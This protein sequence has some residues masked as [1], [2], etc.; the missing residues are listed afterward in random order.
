MTRTRWKILK[1]IEF[2]LIINRAKEEAKREQMPL[3]IMFQDEARFGRINEIRK[4][5][6][7]KGVRPEVIKQI[8]REYT[9]A[10]AAVSPLDGI[11]DFLI[12]PYMR[13]VE[14]EMFLREVSERHSEELILMFMDGASSHK[15]L[16]I[17]ENIIV[18]HIPAYCPQLNPV[19]NMWDEMR[20]K[21]FGNLAFDS[22]EAVEDRLEEACVAYESDRL[23]V[24]SIAGFE[25]II[26]GL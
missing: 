8:V 25:W 20:E 14:M 22:M 2:P 21:Y 16:E 24:Q 13:G 7:P 6:S 1:K 17:P 4:C 19:E 10:Y 12:L 3:R 23:K 26:V 15:G 5:W 11:S 9:Y 18:E